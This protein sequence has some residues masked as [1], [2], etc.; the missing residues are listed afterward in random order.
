P[1]AVTAPLDR[2]L[3]AELAD[4]VDGATAAFEAYDHARALE[5]AESFFWTFCDDYVELVKDRAYGRGALTADGEP[6]ELSEAEIAS[7]RA[8]LWPALDVLLRLFAPFLPFATAEV[9]SWWRS[10]SVHEAAWPTSDALRAAAGDAEAAGLVGLL[11]TAGEALSTLRKVK[12][13]AKVAQRTPLLDVELVAR[14]GAVDQVVLADGDLRA[15]GKVT[16]PFTIVVG[17]PVGA[18]G[19]PVAVA[20]VS[21]TL[22]EAP[23]KD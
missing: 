15:A 2:A 22:G 21:S 13:E 18:D 10:G 8:A 1:S 17:E 5:L 23:A 9:W 12:S 6:A 20:V 19:E 16:G 7:A 4:V 3:L 14:E 11:A